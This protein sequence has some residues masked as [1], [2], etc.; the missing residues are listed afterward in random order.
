MFALKRLTFSTIKQQE[1]TPFSLPAESD[2]P[3]NT[4]FKV[5]QY[6]VMT[7]VSF[8]NRKAGEW[9]SSVNLYT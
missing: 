8:S 9:G 6:K 1:F 4:H 3:S 2:I 5:N 7:A